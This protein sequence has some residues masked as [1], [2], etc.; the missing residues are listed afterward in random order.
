MA[1]PD[2]NLAMEAFLISSPPFPF[3]RVLRCLQ[4][5]SP[6]HVVIDHVDYREDNRDVKQPHPPA[7]EQVVEFLDA[8][9]FVFEEFGVIGIII[10]G[11]FLSAQLA[12]HRHGVGKRS[13]FARTISSC[14]RPR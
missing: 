14:C 3:L 2:S 9:G 4:I 10:H 12:S 1:M 6:G 13:F 5:A 8:V 11:K 7:G